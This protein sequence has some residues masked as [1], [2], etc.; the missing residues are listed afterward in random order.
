MHAAVRGDL[1][2][3]ASLVHGGADPDARDALGETALMMSART[4]LMPVVL[5]LVEYAW[6]DPRPKNKDGDTAESLARRWGHPEVARFLR[7]LAKQAATR[8]LFEA[9]TL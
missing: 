7:G 9:R 5:Y 6:A 4:G 1:T 3:V 2:A 8:R